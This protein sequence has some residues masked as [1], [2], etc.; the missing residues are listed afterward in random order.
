LRDATELRVKEVDRIGRLAGELRRM[1]L[2]VTE[3]QDGFVLEGPARPRGAEV[4]SFGD[5]RLGMAL[6]IAGLVADSP[7]TIA[8]GDCVADSFPGF[9]ETMQKLGARMEWVA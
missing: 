3:R 2:P 7:T 8:G 5:H 6:A 9:V 4:D 1:G